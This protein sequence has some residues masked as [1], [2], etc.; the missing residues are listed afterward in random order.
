MTLRMMWFKSVVRFP[1][2]IRRAQSLIQGRP[3][4]GL[5]TCGQR[6][7]VMDMTTPQLQFD[8]G[9]HLN[10]LALHAK[11][12]D[13]PFYLRCS[14]LLFAAIARKLYG[15]DL[16]S[17]PN[18]TWLSP[19]QPLP[20]DALILR[21]SAV[22]PRRGRL[23]ERH[24]HA[25]LMIGRDNVADTWIMPYPMHPHTLARL[26]SIDLSTLRMNDS[27]RGIF[28]AGRL[29]ASYSHVH[30]DFGVLNRL[31]I[32]DSLRRHFA[33]QV[34]NHIHDAHDPNDI[35]LVDAKTQGLSPDQW[36]PTLAN[37]NFFVCCPGVCQPM[38]HNAVEAMSVGTIPLIEYADRFT[39]G[40]VDGVNAICFRGERGLI[41]AVHRIQNLDDSDIRRMRQ[42][43]IHHYE[44]HLRGDRFLAKLRDS[45]SDTIGDRLIG[46]PFHDTNFFEPTKRVAA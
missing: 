45:H 7:I 34:Q 31:Q 20:S 15:P 46:M 39:P 32:V 42:N 3:L 21:D 35:V 29:K 5:H 41:E 24:T 33:D 28:F 27:R 2:D 14:R 40:L 6:A 43:V 37:Y 26:T 16:L 13:S 18:L 12:I 23:N 19:E 8:C 30:S 11:L 25:R 38:C 17:D 22:S 4:D 10:A 44:T 1:I 9:R 36:L